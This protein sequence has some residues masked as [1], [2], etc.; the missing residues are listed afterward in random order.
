M[1]PDALLWSDFAKGAAWAT[2]GG[3]LPGGTTDTHAQRWG[4]L[5][6]M[7]TTVGAWTLPDTS[8]SRVAFA[9]W[10]SPMPG[11]SALVP[12][13]PQVPQAPGE[14]QN[15]RGSP[16]EHAPALSFLPCEMRLA[17]VGLSGQPT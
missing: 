2:P 10:S 1:H 6:N 12:S 4:P 9:V 7:F 11:V 8:I 16:S 5:Q 3:W 17:A 14:L 15:T 13:T